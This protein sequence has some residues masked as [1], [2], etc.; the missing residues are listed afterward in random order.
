MI[1]QRCLGKWYVP[2]TWIKSVAWQIFV[3]QYLALNQYLYFVTIS[4]VLLVSAPLACAFL[5]DIF[6]FFA[7]RPAIARTC[8]TFLLLFICVATVVQLLLFFSSHSS[9]YT[10]TQTHEHTQQQQRQNNEGSTSLLFFFFYK[11]TTV[12]T[13][14]KSHVFPSRALYL[15]AS[16]CYLFF[17]LFSPVYR[18]DA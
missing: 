8:F 5:F 9:R 2:R 17:S 6:F 16:T 1:C 13:E 11:S 18:N 14:G 15:R 4:A 12:T 3:S 7:Y 10:H